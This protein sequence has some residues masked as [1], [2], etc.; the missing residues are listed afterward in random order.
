VRAF[1]PIL[2]VFF[3]LVG[4]ASAGGPAMMVGAAEDVAKQQD[5]AFAKTEMDM[6]RL[7]GLD[8]IRV[9]QTW[10]RG[11]VK[12]GPND[13][14]T[15][16]NAITAAQF[17]GLRVVLSLYPFGSSV[18]PASD[19]D[20]ADF[21]AFAADVVGR[22]PLV[23]DVIVGNEPNL[24]RFWLPQFDA[25]G[26][27]AAAPAYL[28][29]L[30]ATY[31]AIKLV[32]AHTTV[33]GG[34]L[35]PRGVD[36]PGTGRDTHSPT[37]FIA[38]LGAAY[39]A[40][41]RLVP[42]MDAFA[43]HPYPE[44]SST[45]P[46]L[47]HPNGTSIG[48]A[49]YPKLVGLLGAAFDGTAQRGSTLPILYDEFGIETQLPPAKA[50]LYTGSEP[51]TTKP[52][53]EATQAL[54]L[55]QAMQMT[56]CQPTVLGLLLFHVQD[57]PV[58]SAWQSGEFYVDGT[59]KASLGPVRLAAGAVHRGV[60]AACPGLLLTPRLVISVGKPDRK[61]VK[62]FLTCSLDCNYTVT[63]DRRSLRGLA[64]ARVRTTLLFK[65]ALAPGAHRVTARGTV[66][67][68]AGPAGVA[69]RS[70]QSR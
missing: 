7:A 38:D 46:A 63:V 52:V 48:L 59:P 44:T 33:Y 41:G 26:A 20:R 14:I 50:A 12:L 23:H 34:A 2:L 65:V 4:E 47:A 56:F 60:A 9:T 67:L 15:L 51:S 8:S 3:A 30:A 24:N 64:T 42:V 21:A 11:Q 32:R 40:S 16:G 70:F 43:F 28:Q 27:D 66:P 55:T 62:V 37:A 13:E 10:T 31:D 54:M 29:L 36:K 19:Q 53:D 22:Y 49:D 39:R 25:E 57:E 1:C 5:A 6:A 61:S 68:N 45:G 18:T 69:A 58:L 17:S 35:A